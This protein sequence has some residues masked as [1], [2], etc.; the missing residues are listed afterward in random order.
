MSAMLCTAIVRN[1]VCKSIPLAQY[2][3]C[4]FL[5]DPMPLKEA[6]LT[7]ARKYTASSCH[8]KFQIWPLDRTQKYANLRSW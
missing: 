5:P 3:P 8:I 4:S 1:V 7:I 6:I 2:L